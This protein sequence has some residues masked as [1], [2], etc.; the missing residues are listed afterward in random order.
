MFAHFESLYV[1]LQSNSSP[2][3][4]DD[5]PGIDG[6][7]EGDVCSPV[8]LR[9]REPITE[10]R[11]RLKT[12]FS[13]SNYIST[14]R[15]SSTQ[16]GLV[17]SHTTRCLPSVPD[18]SNITCHAVITVQFAVQIPDNRHFLLTRH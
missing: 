12:P 17:G 6:P 10:R 13:V 14:S 5:K 8:P 18:V 9:G 7:S 3:K 16:R 2:L 1:S 4:D 11:Y 15:L